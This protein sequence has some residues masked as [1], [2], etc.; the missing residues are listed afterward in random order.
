MGRSV[1]GFSARRSAHGTLGPPTP[2]LEP[3]ALKGELCRWVEAGVGFPPA[4][5]PMAR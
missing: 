5:A 2:M 4:G 3:N 1:R